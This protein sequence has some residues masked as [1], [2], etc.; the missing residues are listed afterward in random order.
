M[1]DG[2][3]WWYRIAS[4]QW[5]NNFYASADDFWNNGKTSGNFHGSSLVDFNVPAC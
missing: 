5:N 2:N 3:L 1:Q 4:P